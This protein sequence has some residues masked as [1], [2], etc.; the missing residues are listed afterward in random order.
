VTFAIATAPAVTPAAPAPGAS[1]VSPTG[2]ASIGA[3]GAG[4]DRRALTT[5][6]PRGFLASIRARL[7]PAGRSS[8]GMPAGPSQETPKV[9][10]S[11]VPS[12]S[13]APALDPPA[14]P[15]PQ[16]ADLLTQFLPF[17]RATLDEA[18]DRF[19]GEFDGLG[20]G[21]PSWREPM[22]WLPASM[23][24]AAAVLATEVGRRSWQRSRDD[25]AEGLAADGGIGLLRF[26]GLRGAD[27]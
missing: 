26:P 2:P 9:G 23:A 22:S 12:E 5:G 8:T 20:S 15:D 17:D 13:G 7:N 16:A 14:L 1:A 3:V 4:F 25:E 19:L 6:D 27:D 11:D 21:L 10:G 24:F 18:L